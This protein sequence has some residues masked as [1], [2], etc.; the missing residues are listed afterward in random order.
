M[1][2]ESYASGVEFLAALPDKEPHCVVIDLP[3]FNGFDVLARLA[4]LSTRLPL[5]VITDHKGQESRVEAVL[6]GAALLCKPFD[7]ATVL[8]AL[9]SALQSASRSQA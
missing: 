4:P 6:P 2:V 5:V 3:R 1:D 9:A 7:E 8:D